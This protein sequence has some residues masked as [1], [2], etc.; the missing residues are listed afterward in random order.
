[1]SADFSAGTYSHSAQNLSTGDGV[2]PVEG[3]GQRLAI[4]LCAGP[5]FEGSI[6]KPSCRAERVGLGQGSEKLSTAARL[7]DSAVLRHDRACRRGSQLALSRRFC[8]ACS[9]LGG[10]SDTFK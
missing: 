5:A 7:Y 3:A 1:A 4:K 6:T 2:W 10:R 9:T 8:A